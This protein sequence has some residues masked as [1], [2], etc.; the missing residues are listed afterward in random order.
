MATWQPWKEEQYKDLYEGGGS[1]FAETF[2]KAQDAIDKKRLADAQAEETLAAIED[3]KKARAQKTRLS[4]ALSKSTPDTRYDTL[5]DTLA[6]LGDYEGMM[7]IEEVQRARAEKEAAREQ[8]QLS[9]ITTL[10]K[11]NPDLAARIWNSSPFK[12]KYG[13][14]TAEEFY[15]PEVQSGAG[16]LYTVGLDGEIDFKYKQPVKGP[17]ATKPSLRSAYNP[18]TKQNEFV[19]FNSPDVQKRLTTGELLPPK[20]AQGGQSDLLSRLKKPDEEETAERIPRSLRPPAGTIKT[21]K[22]LERGLGG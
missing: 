10:A 11:S 18:A 2:L 13:E 8:S 5:R 21:R 6:E 16:T 19:D 12:T 17:A 3:K 15:K 9:A 20:S 7:N 1:S 14:K 22:I 4:E